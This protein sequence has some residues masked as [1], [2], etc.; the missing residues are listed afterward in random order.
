MSVLIELPRVCGVIDA[1]Y[2]ARY[3]RYDSGALLLAEVVGV[4]WQA[5]QSLTNEQTDGTAESVPGAGRWGS[6]SIAHAAKAGFALA[7]GLRETKM[8]AISSCVDPVARIELRTIARQSVW[9][10]HKAHDALTTGSDA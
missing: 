6:W 8:A 10:R 7:V 5:P 4:D 1:P 3:A 2:L 9:T